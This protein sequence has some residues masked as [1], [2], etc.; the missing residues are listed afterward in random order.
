[1]TQTNNKGRIIGLLYLIIAIIGGFSIGYMPSEIIHLENSFLTYT[2]FQEQTSL[3]YLGL[4]GDLI[5]FLAELI[6]TVLLYEMYKPISKTFSTIAT[7]ARFSMAIIMG[8]NLVNYLIPAFIYTNGE[9]IL[10]GTALNLQQ[11]ISLI[12]FYAHKI[13]EY[14]WQIFFFV[15]LFILGILIKKSTYV[16]KKIGIAMLLG[17]FGYFFQSLFFFLNI[18]NGYISTITNILLTIAVIGELTFTFWLLIK[19]IKITSTNKI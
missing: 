9:N 1:M 7:Y 6:L 5:V 17:S 16:P 12:F 14:C 11:D 19:G 18:Q 3:F 8:L 2:K 15:H 13:G 4:T 10:T